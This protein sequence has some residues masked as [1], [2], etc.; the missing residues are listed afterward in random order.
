[1]STLI[2]NNF[3][4][5]NNKIIQS[6]ILDKLSK[7]LIIPFSNLLGKIYPNT[8]KSITVDNSYI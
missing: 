8:V 3:Y 6:I 2:L 4:K 5:L 1:M 7:N